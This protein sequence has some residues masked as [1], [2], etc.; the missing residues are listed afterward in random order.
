MSGV[1]REL[2]LFPLGAVVLFPDMSLNLRVFESR[3]KHLVSDVLQ[4]DSS[5]GIALIREGRE[6]GMPAVPHE[7]GTIARITELTPLDGGNLYISTVGSQRFRILEVLEPRPYLLARVEVL[8]EGPEEAPEELVSEARQAMADYVRA[9]TA[10]Q[11]GMGPRRPRAARCGLAVVSHCE[12]GAGGASCEAAAAGGPHGCGAADHGGGAV[13]A[14][15]PTAAK[16]PAGSRAREQVQ[17]ELRPNGEPVPN[18]MT[19]IDKR[20]PFANLM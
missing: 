6:V 10:M 8:D 5:F 11:G 19:L 3:Y 4:Q 12:H 15:R 14:E 18:L 9:V 1:E 17:Q 2:P 13:A 7:V 20:I 16:P